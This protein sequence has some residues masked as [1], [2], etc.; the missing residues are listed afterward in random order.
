M[1]TL[2]FLLYL[3]KQEFGKSQTENSAKLQKYAHL[4]RK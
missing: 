4:K 1:R 2:G 3:A